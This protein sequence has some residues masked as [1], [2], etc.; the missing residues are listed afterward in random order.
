MKINQFGNV[1]IGAALT[2]PMIHR[3]IEEARRENRSVL[4]AGT[5]SAVRNNWMNVISTGA[6]RPG[7]LFLG[8]AALQVAPALVGV[9]H[10][11]IRQRNDEIRLSHTPFS[12]RFEH[13]DWTWREQQRGMQ[14]ISGARSLVGSEAGAFHRRYARR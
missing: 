2:Y 14:S 1:G 4:W 8:F 7:M 9:A 12:Q 11:M 10:G 5:K 13:T 6:S 3:D